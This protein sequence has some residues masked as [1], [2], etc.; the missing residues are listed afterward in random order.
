MSI[1][2]R[3]GTTEGYGTADPPN[4]HDLFP[5]F[6]LTSH[7]RS[8][9]LSLVH[10]FVSIAQS[11]GIAAFPFRLPYHVLVHI[12]VPDTEVDNFYVDV[13]EV[14]ICGTTFLRSWN[15]KEPMSLSPTYLPLAR[16]IF[17]TF[18]IT[19]F[20]VLTGT[21]QRVPHLM[22]QADPLDC[23]TFITEVLIPSLSNVREVQNDLRHQASQQ[24]LEEEAITA[25]EIKLRT[26]NTTVHYFVGILFKHGS[27]H[28]TAL[29]T[30]WD[31]VMSKSWNREISQDAVYH[32]LLRDKN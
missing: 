14:L 16:A 25:Q 5:H 24:S 8:I 21:G 19:L 15:V 26:P 27:L 3:S 18:S 31:P 17:N 1:R 9:L 10:I 7:K 4:F 2:W 29:I 20:L 13:F 12:T 11:F 6:Y 30:G 32:T 22:S 28:Y 23:A